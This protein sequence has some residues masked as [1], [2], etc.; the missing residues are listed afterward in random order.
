[1]GKHSLDT[2]GHKEKDPDATSGKKLELAIKVV[3]LMTALVEL[4]AVMLHVGL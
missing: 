3:A 2:P 1:M 4:I